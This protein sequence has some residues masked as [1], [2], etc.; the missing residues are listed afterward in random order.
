M[1]FSRLSYPDRLIYSTI[2][3]FIA[4]KASDQP[5][6]ELPAVNNEL[7]TVPVIL[8]FKDQSSADIV[9]AQLKNLSQKIQVTVLPIFVSHK[10]KQHLKLREVRPPIVNQ[11]SLV[12]QFKCDLCDAGYVGYTRRHL[13]QRVDEHK[14]ASSSIGKH[15]R[16]EHSYVPS[17]L[18]K[19]FTILKK[20]KSKFDCL[21]YE[22]FL[23]NELRPSLNVQ[24]DP[25]PKW[26][27]KI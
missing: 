7:K 17:D 26:R 5:V 10:I 1:V 15:F 11:Q 4:V 23:I 6:L 25:S 2:S 18:A 21:I 14:N 8:P 19:N 22:M 20:C 12:Y 27:P 13:H 24:S 16:L 3:R 9:R